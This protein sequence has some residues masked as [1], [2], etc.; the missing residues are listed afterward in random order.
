M[1]T[2][3]QSCFTVHIPFRSSRLPFGGITQN[4]PTKET[5]T[6]E[7]DSD[8]RKWYAAHTGLCLPLCPVAVNTSRNSPFFC[9]L[10]VLHIVEVSQPGMP[11]ST[12]LTL[13]N[14]G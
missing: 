9:G 13:A 3:H 12:Q 4:T 7:E 8:R 5:H 2:A 14:E 10:W 1:N 6:K 11:L